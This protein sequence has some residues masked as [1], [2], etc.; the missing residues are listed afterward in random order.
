MRKNYKILFLEDNDDL[1]KSLTKWAKSKG[2]ELTQVKYSNEL[3]NLLI[4]EGNNYHGLILDAKGLTDQ[5][6]NSET[7]QGLSQ[8]LT[9]LKEDRKPYIIYTAHMDLIEEGGLIELLNPKLIFKKASEKQAAFEK[10]E[11]EIRNFDKTILKEEH[12][13]LFEALDANFL[14]KKNIKGFKKQFFKKEI[15]SDQDDIERDIAHT[16]LILEE[17]LAIFLDDVIQYSH[18]NVLTSEEKIVIIN[19]HKSEDKKDFKYVPE[20]TITQ[21]RSLNKL[22]QAGAHWKDGIK[23]QYLLKTSNNLTAH[24]IVSYYQ[25]YVK[26]KR[27]S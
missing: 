18:N 25:K 14:D 5:N 27:E 6:Q 22:S 12:P 20:I 16:R 24:L 9:Y 19:K 7:M 10:L 21:L 1:A 11:S 4:S 23:T 15:S 2:F 3:I 8:V 13:D 26:L 17:L